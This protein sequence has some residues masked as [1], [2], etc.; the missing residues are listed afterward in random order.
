MG[1]GSQLRISSCIWE[2]A[3]RHRELNSQYKPGSS[4][5][6]ENPS[7]WKKKTYI[8]NPYAYLT[9]AYALHTTGLFECYLIASA[10]SNYAVFGESITGV[11]HYNQSRKPPTDQRSN[12]CK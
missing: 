7:E 9:P 1:A 3:Q 10:L 11:K 6:T 12:K 8:D 5:H 2:I 4:T